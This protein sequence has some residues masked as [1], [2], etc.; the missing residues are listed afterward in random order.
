MMANLENGKING[1]GKQYNID[2]KLLFEEKN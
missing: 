1:N 2:G